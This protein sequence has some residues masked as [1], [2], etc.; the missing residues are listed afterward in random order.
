[1][2]C[3]GLLRSNG[4]RP[5]EAIRK[6]YDAHNVNVNVRGMWDVIML[7]NFVRK[8]LFLFDFGAQVR[9]VSVGRVRPALRKANCACAAVIPQTMQFGGANKKNVTVDRTVELPSDAIRSTRSL[10]WRSE[11]TNVLVHTGTLG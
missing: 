11:D 6:A 4:N 9:I 7:Y 8:L 3:K 1:M 10:G 2:H 5:G